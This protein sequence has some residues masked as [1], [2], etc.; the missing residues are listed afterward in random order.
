MPEPAQS[1]L[2]ILTHLIILTI[3][4]GKYYY[5]AHFHYYET[6]AM[7]TVTQLMVKEPGFYP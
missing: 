2:P 1:A 7:L 4:R 5:Y 3:Q 6:E